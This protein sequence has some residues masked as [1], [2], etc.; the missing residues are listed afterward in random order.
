MPPVPDSIWVTMEALSNGLQTILGGLLLGVYLGGSAAMGDFYAASSD[1]D[2]LVVT[3]G[4]LSM[5][6][7]IAVQLLHRDLVRRYP[8]AE[9]LEGDYS[10]LDYL[11][12][13]GT[14]QPVPGCE[15]GVFLPKVGEIMLSADNL[16]CFREYGIRFFGPHIR[17]VIPPVSK[18]NVR[19]AVV[20]ML[21]DGPG[22]ADSA[23]ESAAAILNLLRSGYALEAGTAATKSSGAAWAMGNL[24]PAWHPV[25]QVALAVRSGDISPS[26]AALLASA[27]PRLVLAMRTRFA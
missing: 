8:D 14:S 13:A 21:Q 2:F 19:D 15:H 27:L 18:A 1:L 23:Q 5:E 17:E 22:H 26:D 10:P 16:W 7:T 20:S 11:V 4:T 12:P 6:D 9:R 24:A 3:N 25:I